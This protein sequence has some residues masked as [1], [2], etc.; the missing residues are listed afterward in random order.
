MSSLP[1]RSYVSALGMGD[2]TSPVQMDD[3]QEDAQ[4]RSSSALPTAG[5]ATAARL[6]EPRPS[7]ARAMLTR[8][9]AETTPSPVA[10]AGASAIQ[11]DYQA[12]S[13][14]L[15]EQLETANQR[16]SILQS[17]NE[18]L[19]VKLSEQIS[20]RSR[21]QHA[22]E[23][24]ARE[25]E[26]LS[27][28]L[29]EEANKLVASESKER[30]AL[31][32]QLQQANQQLAELQDHHALE[33]AQLKELKERITASSSQI[34]P[35]PD[36]AFTLEAIW[37][38]SFEEW[39]ML[40]QDSV[41]R[42]VWNQANRSLFLEFCQWLGIQISPS[43]N[44]LEGSSGDDADDLDDLWSGDGRH[45]LA[46][47]IWEHEISPTL[48]FPTRRH[49]RSFTRRLAKALAANRLT[50]EPE[51][52]SSIDTSFLASF[53]HWTSLST[54]DLYMQTTTISNTTG[55]DRPSRCSLCHMP[56]RDP[57]VKIHKFSLE[58]QNR[59]FTLFSKE[60]QP[61]DPDVFWLDESCHARIV[62]V[63][64]YFSFLR[65][66]HSGL[67]HSASA[68]ILFL[69]WIQLLRGMFYSRTTGAGYFIASDMALYSAQKRA[70]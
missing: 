32:V 57:H 59:H 19:T 68:E 46:Q 9:R 51:A 15:K 42:I 40:G 45:P 3:A 36:L 70:E 64:N 56:W 49:S 21:L 29:F 69:H 28:S 67:Y 18:L 33:S 1:I 65:H 16:I 66:Y 25:L 53:S 63:C 43:Q 2:D 6:Y 61:S 23:E 52:S 17:E 14:T 10:M 12:L 4:P 37:P 11:R 5:V 26:E 27:K 55:K 38:K 54:T 47:R 30:H 60:S 39:K 8:M 20:L 41:E 48:S 24:M 35:G 58:E 7:S 62:S 22:K 34:D 44:L 31:Q 50:I 13:Q